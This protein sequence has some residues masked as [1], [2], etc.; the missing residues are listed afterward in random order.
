MKG[1][2]IVMSGWFPYAPAE[3]LAQRKMRLL[4]M[5][6]A[7]EHYAAADPPFCPLCNGSGL[8]TEGGRVCA[9]CDGAVTV[10]FAPWDQPAGSMW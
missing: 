8:L 10:S 5:N 4:A 7:G 1:E 3:S 9:R 6:V 2:L